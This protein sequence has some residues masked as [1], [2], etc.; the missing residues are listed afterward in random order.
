MRRTRR[1]TGTRPLRVAEFTA[2]VERLARSVEPDYI[3]VWLHSPL[4]ALDDE[5]PIDLIAR[6]EFQ[7]V[8]RLIAALESPVAS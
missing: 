6:G 1:P 2:I 4:A 5:K 8:N 3:S 7:P